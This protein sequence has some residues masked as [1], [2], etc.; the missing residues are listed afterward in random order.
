MFGSL[1]CF[2]A[3][4]SFSVPAPGLSTDNLFFLC[5]AFFLAWERT[6]LLCCSLVE[7]VYHRLSLWSLMFFKIALRNKRFTRLI[8]MGEAVCCIVKNLLLRG[9]WLGLVPLWATEQLVPAFAAL[10]IVSFCRFCSQIVGRILLK[11]AKRKL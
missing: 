9:R 7:A 2:N 8:P 3:L 10:C 11:A 6:Q 5:I 4:S 1:S